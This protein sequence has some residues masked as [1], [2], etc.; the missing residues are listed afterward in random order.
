[1]SAE[2]QQPSTA[3]KVRHKVE[4]PKNH[5]LTFIASILLTM[6]AFAA[7]I[8][9]D[10]T[11]AFILPFILLL[12]VGQVIMQLAYWMHMKDR[13]HAYAIVGLVMGTVIAITAVIAAVY[14][15]WW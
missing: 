15:M 4:G 10:M 13:G 5:Y 9:G 3:P 8:Y 6:L 7:V 1:M 11:K 2:H 12:A 14:W